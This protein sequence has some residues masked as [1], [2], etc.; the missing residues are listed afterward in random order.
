MDLNADYK[1]DSEH[2][3]LIQRHYRRLVEQL[4][5]RDVGLIAELFAMKVIDRRDKEELESMDNSSIKIER[6]LSTLSRTSSDQ[7]KRFLLALDR[8]GQQHLADVL[9]EKMTEEITG[10]FHLFTN[11]NE[12]QYATDAFWIAMYVKDSQSA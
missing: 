3:E 9:R 8:T 10:Y 4:N 5:V 11:A 6:L 2:A 12:L 1:I 7:W